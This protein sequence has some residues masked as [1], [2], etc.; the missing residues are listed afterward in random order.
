M[1]LRVRRMWLPDG[2][3]CYFT[4]IRNVGALDLVG[5]SS[6]VYLFTFRVSLG[7]LSPPAQDG[8]SLIREHILTVPPV[9]YLNQYKLSSDTEKSQ[10]RD[11]Q[12]RFG[13]PGC[14]S[15][16]QIYNS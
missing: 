5:S 15:T 14:C 11:G 6:C 1:G 8:T 3:R 10:S 4:S 12:H 9:F 13:L 2:G 16:A 7:L